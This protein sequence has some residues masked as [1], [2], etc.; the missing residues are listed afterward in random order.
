MI[1]DP[2]LIQLEKEQVEDI[3]YYHQLL[4][5][6]CEKM[7]VGEEFRMKVMAKE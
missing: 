7:N 2:N 3:E 1:P 4:D 5:M 6:T